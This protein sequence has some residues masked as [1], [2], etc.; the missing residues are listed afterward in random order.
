VIRPIASDAALIVARALS[1]SALNSGILHR[2][3]ENEI[4]VSFAIFARASDDC[5]KWA[6]AKQLKM[7]ELL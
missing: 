4:S 6:V 5:E 1:S 7:F 2:S 3:L